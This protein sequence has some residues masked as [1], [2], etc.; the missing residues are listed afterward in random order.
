M[1]DHPLVVQFALPI[2]FRRLRRRARR[3]EVLSRRP[4]AWQV[5][6]A[7][8]LRVVAVVSGQGPARAKRATEWILRTLHPKALL[9]A[10]LAGG[11]L[12]GQAP[13]DLVI[14]DA[15]AL[16]GDRD[17]L[18]RRVAAD[19]RLA[20]ALKAVLGGRGSR[21]VRGAAIQVHVV[22]DPARK[23]ALG[24]QGAAVVDM[25]THTILTTA[26]AAGCPAAGLRVVLDPVDREIPRSLQALSGLQGGRWFPEV[27]GAW[28]LPFEAMA[29]FRFGRDLQ[30]A[31]RSLG[32]ALALCLPALDRALK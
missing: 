14:V 20:E 31:Q 26:A 18:E 17:Q 13:G 15:A 2:E 23:R 11:T 6:L 30:A 28:R 27:L 25:E 8:G 12:A 5:E 10:G 3:S 1:D 22:A 7:D 21:A 4:S 19:A 32:D 9:V 29:V 24:R 16:G